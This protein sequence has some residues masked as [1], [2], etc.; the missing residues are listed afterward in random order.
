MTIDHSVVFDNVTIEDSEIDHSLIDRDEGN[1][2]QRRTHRRVDTGRVTVRPLI[3]IKICIDIDIDSD[4]GNRTRYQIDERHLH[5]EPFSVYRT[6][7][8][9]G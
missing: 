3:E 7:R 6:T 5:A 8:A 4:A 1:E 9:Y 2:A